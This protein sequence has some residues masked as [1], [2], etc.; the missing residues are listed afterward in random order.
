MSSNNMLRPQLPRFEGKIH[1]QWSQQM[2]V[3][4]GYQ[5]LW[6]IVDRG[7]LVPESENDLLQQQLNELRDVRKKDK[8]RHYFLSTKL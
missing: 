7:Y 3:L 5:D 8:K 4:Y 2:K 6:D 1:T